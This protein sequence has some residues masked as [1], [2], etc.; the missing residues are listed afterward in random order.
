MFESGLVSIHYVSLSILIPGWDSA[1]DAKD[2]QTDLR[3]EEVLRLRV[4]VSLIIYFFSVIPN[5][6][7]FRFFDLKI[8]KYFWIKFQVFHINFINFGISSLISSFLI[9]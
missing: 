1:S 3:E 5:S 6:F 7:D 8:L 9:R 2:L 4:W